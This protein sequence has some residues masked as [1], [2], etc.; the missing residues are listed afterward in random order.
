MMTRQRKESAWRKQ[1]K[2][3]LRKTASHSVV[4]VTDSVTGGKVMKKRSRAERGL[5]NSLPD[6]DSNRN[7]QFAEDARLSPLLTASVQ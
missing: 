1:G 6:E 4:N 5:A 2:K 7:S 3:K